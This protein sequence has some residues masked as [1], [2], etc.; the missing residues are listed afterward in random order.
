MSVEYKRTVCGEGVALTEIFDK[1]FKSFAVVVRLIAP[2]DA[3]KTPLYLMAF[4]IISMCS[5]KYPEKEQLTKALVKLY[6]S[7]IVSDEQKF[8]D[9]ESI[10][11]SL[12]CL[13]DEYTI[14][15]EKISDKAVDMFLDCLFDPL[16]ENGGF[17][18]KYFELTRKEMLDDI[19]SIVNSKRR[20][21]AQLAKPYIFK[22][23][24]AG[25]N[26]YD[27]REAIE[28]ATA[29]SV[30][31][32]YKEFLR[33]A[34]FEITV[35]GA[36]LGDDQKQKIV[37][38]ILSIEGRKPVIVNDRRS[39][40]PIKSELCCKEAEIEARQTQLIIAYK[41]PEINEDVFKIFA[42]I[43]GASPLSKLFTNVREK[44]SLC[45][46]CDAY[47]IVT[48]NTILVT[49]GLDENDLDKA[50]TAIDEQI[51]AVRTGD[52]TD[53]E[54]EYAKKYLIDAYLGDYDSKIK[55]SGWFFGRWIMSSSDS[56]EEK[57][58]KVRAVSREQVI[59]AAKSFVKD[60]QFVLKAVT[61]GVEDNDS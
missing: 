12:N 40:S 13:A 10:S 35:T 23:E 16:I 3:V 50:I 24:G 15:K 28:N 31:E 2:A 57:T 43:L 54:L 9:F 46:Y 29:Q 22:G 4:D 56:P 27:E 58:D 14:G 52:F 7:S 32:A 47:P 55:L 44:M 26:Q 59:E 37:E 41:C 38:R 53:E 11:L 25:I 33:T 49:C 61:G 1:K 20:Y 5:R 42:A 60:T 18:Q 8:S 39:P 34:V 51:N 36:E 17:S 21:A 19:S 6:S 48:K 45:Y 30:Y